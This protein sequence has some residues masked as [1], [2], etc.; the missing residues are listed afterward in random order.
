M[1]VAKATIGPPPRIDV[2]RPPLID[3]HPPGSVLQ[4]LR[5]SPLSL[6]SFDS[7]DDKLSAAAGY[8]SITSAMGAAPAQW[9]AIRRGR[10]WEFPT[11][12]PVNWTTKENSPAKR[13]D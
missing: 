9:A 7:S 4:F 6:A 10:G 3:R 5:K 8:T 2:R 12:A 13:A 1:A 11:A